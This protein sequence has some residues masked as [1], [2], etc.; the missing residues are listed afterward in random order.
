MQRIINNYYSGDELEIRYYLDNHEYALAHLPPCKG[1]SRIIDIYNQGVRKRVDLTAERKETYSQKIN[2]VVIKENCEFGN[3]K[4]NLSR[5]IDHPAVPFDIAEKIFIKFRTHHDMLPGWQLDVSAVR[6]CA[7]R[8]V[9]FYKQQ[10][11]STFKHETN[12][13]DYYEFELEFIGDKPQ[14]IDPLITYKYF[15]AKYELLRE[16]RVASNLLGLPAVK[17]LSQLLPKAIEP[18]LDN[19]IANFET[20]EGMIIRDKIDGERQ[21]LI[22]QDEVMTVIGGDTVAK[23]TCDSGVYVFDTEYLDNVWYI[24]HPLVI[25][26]KLIVDLRDSER[27]KLLSNLK[28]PVDIK[29]CPFITTG[30]SDF[31]N[32]STTYQR[33]GLLL[34]EDGSYFKQRVIKWKPVDE[35]TFDFVAIKCPEWLQGKAPYI[36]DCKILCAGYNQAPNLGFSHK[37]WCEY[38]KQ[39]GDK[40]IA[41]PFAPGDNLYVHIFYG[42]IAHGQCGEFA[43]INGKFMLKRI[44]NDKKSW[45]NGGVDRGNNF[46]VCLE[47]WA[48]LQR[49]FTLD[50]LSGCTKPNPLAKLVNDAKEILSNIEYQ[51]LICHMT[52]FVCRGTNAIIHEEKTDLFPNTG[53]GYGCRIIRY[54]QLG[55]VQLAAELS[56][57]ADVVISC[58]PKV[59]GHASCISRFVASSGTIIMFFQPLSVDQSSLIKEFEKSGFEN[60][61]LYEFEL[62]HALVMNKYTKEYALAV[63]NPH[64]SNFTTYKYMRQKNKEIGLMLGILEPTP[65]QVRPE[66]GQLLI[67]IEYICQLDR[68]S[69][70][71]YIGPHL[72]RLVALF[73]KIRFTELAEN[74]ECLISHLKY[75]ESRVLI[76]E[77]NPV[78]G[79]CDMTCEDRQV[80]RGKMMY[81]LYDEPTSTRVALCYTKSR[82]IWNIPEQMFKKEMEVFHNTYRPSAFKY[83]SPIA[84]FDG[85]YDCKTH[86]LIV[87]KFAKYAGIDFQQAMNL[88]GKE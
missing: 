69:T 2:K 24:L 15:T 86:L 33:D 64:V 40:Y 39:R 38:T 66:F 79:M 28:L 1:Y 43:F 87:Q 65:R 25:D 20:A 57:G 52:P 27:L 75:D 32:R 78:C 88:I 41:Y 54:Q 4:I 30:I 46:G 12:K 68:I 62:A 13:W 59:L 70:I 58:D 9:A 3:Y 37:R 18:S 22:M 56:Q 74:T 83:R 36:G 44:R 50:Y 42:D 35:Y 73:P 84:G 49:P 14:A 55:K 11:L 53:V 21:L 51:T 80:L 85:C 60:P 7:L 10:L 29:I 8:D 17:S 26:G 34:A 77:I 5:E 63:A 81:Y 76:D 82:D 31:Y 45:L 23:Y 16:L 72:D 61:V 19:W 48:K 6:V 47:I 67:D 71:M